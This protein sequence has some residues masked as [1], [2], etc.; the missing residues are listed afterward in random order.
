MKPR[1]NPIRILIHKVTD[2][3]LLQYPIAPKST[4]YNRQKLT[5]FQ[6]FKHFENGKVIAFKKALGLK[7][8]FAAL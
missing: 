4:I 5:F 1:S 3:I 8:F 2:T 7:I 6:A